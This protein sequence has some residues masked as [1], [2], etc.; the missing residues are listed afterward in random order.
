MIADL[1]GCGLKAAE[2]LGDALRSDVGRLAERGSCQVMR[3]DSSPRLSGLV[4]LD[5]RGDRNYIRF[6]G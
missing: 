4:G 5:A 6:R 1:L 2:G 3:V